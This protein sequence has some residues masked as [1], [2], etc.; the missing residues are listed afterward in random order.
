MEREQLSLFDIITLQEKVR[1]A[2]EL[3]KEAYE[4]TGGKLFISFSGGKDSTILRHIALKLYPDM[5]V[6]YS[7][8]TNEL[9]EVLE[10]VKTFP[11][12]ITVTPKMNFKKVLK[13]HGFPLVSKEV[14]QKANELKK[15]NGKTTRNTRMYGDKK[16]N[17][18]LSTKWRFLAEQEF[19]VTHKCCKI[20]KKDPLNK[21]AKENGLIPVIALMQDESMLRQQLALYGKD[22]G[23]KVYPFLRSEWTE[24]DIWNYAKL[25]GIRFAECYYDR[26]INGVFVPKRKRTGCEYCGFG[27]T[28][29]TEDRFERSKI[30]NPK[31][32]ESIM[33]IE[34]NGVTFKDAIGLVKTKGIK[35]ILDL[36]GVKLKMTSNY[37]DDNEI[38]CNVYSVESTIKIRK[39]PS[40]ES[41]N[42]KNS[43]GHYG[44]YADAPHP[45]TGV[46]RWVFVESKNGYHCE[47]CNKTI[48]DD[49]HMFNTEFCVTDRLITYIEKNLNK[50]SFHEIVEETGISF[51]KVYDIVY[52]L[53]EKQKI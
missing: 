38:N 7:N 25:H 42:I 36:Y 47:D 17:G 45:D 49:L 16:G 18:R 15:T 28:L 41:K 21:W 4:R 19:D 22:D 52:N 29:E 43:F 27:I 35:P 26:I 30:T 44:N 51:E 40:C 2:E 46:K 10:Y 3:I 14:S 1:L 32:H 31:R 24:E 53:L 33:K 20:L 37:I 6:V 9:K 48:I 39:C 8:T 13:I 12:V 50:K 5:P 11:D 23:K 34:N